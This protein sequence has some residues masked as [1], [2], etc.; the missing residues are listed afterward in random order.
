M[1]IHLN[2]LKTT[3]NGEF[4]VTYNAICLSQVNCLSSLEVGSI[5]TCIHMNI[6]ANLVVNCN[7]NPV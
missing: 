2:T 3:C 4:Y 6:I 1:T 7:S 5:D